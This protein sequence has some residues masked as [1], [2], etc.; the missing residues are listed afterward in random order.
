VP[1]VV[2]DSVAAELRPEATLLLAVRTPAH[3]VRQAAAAAAREIAGLDGGWTTAMGLRVRDRN[4]PKYVS[5]PVPVPGGVLLLVDAGSTPAERLAAIPEI[6]VRA[7]TTAG[8]TDASIEIPAQMGERTWLAGPAVR[9]WLIGPQGLEHVGSWFAD[10]A[11]PWL[12]SRGEPVGNVMSAEIPLTWETFPQVADEV[13]AAGQTMSVA[14]GETAWG[15][16]VHR[17]NAVAEASLTEPRSGWAVDQGMT[18][19]REALRAA[20]DRLVWAGI[21]V[22]A[23]ARFSVIPRWY[24]RERPS[25]DVIADIAVPDGM[26]WQVIS[27]GHIVRL[28]G[29]PA[30]SEALGGGRYE[31]TVGAPYQWMPEHPDRPHMLAAARRLLGACLL[32]PEEAGRLSRERLAR[33]FE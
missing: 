7:L 3:A 22:V 32:D 29:P 23:D 8:V 26:W 30:G 15:A 5:E 33:L 20:A 1:I 10:V 6:L 2:A 24:S 12:R 19:L 28:G 4:G 13:L 9:A 16:V 18:A 14:A 11:G 21:D 31:L 27:A 25:V 17:M